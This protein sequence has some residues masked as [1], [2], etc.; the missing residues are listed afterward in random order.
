MKKIRAIFIELL[1]PDWMSQVALA[2][3]IRL[4]NTSLRRIVD[5][6]HE[7]TAIKLPQIVVMAGAFGL[8]N[9]CWLTDGKSIKGDPMMEKVKNNIKEEFVNR[10]L[11]RMGKHNLLVEQGKLKNRSKV[12]AY[13]K[14]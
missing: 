8:D 4:P 13:K 7:G 2:D 6:E 9:L 10:V 11:E 3:I 1:E 5:G 12:R 14:Y